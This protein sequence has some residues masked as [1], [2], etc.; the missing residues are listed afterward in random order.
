MVCPIVE[1]LGLLG[2]ATPIGEGTGWADLSP[3]NVSGTAVSLVQNLMPIS[4]F[5]QWYPFG[6]GDRYNRADQDAAFRF[7]LKIR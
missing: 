3:S 7:E 6:V 2:D 4:G 1:S 5:A